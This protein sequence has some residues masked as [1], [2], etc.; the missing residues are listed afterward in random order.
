LA[1]IIN[2][3][4]INAL[5]YAY[6]DIE[7]PTLHI[8]INEEPNYLQLDIIDNGIGFDH[9]KITESHSFGL[10]L[11]NTLVQQLE[12]SIE[13]KQTIGTHWSIKIKIAKGLDRKHGKK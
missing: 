1:L 7:K 5:K 11:L 8:I 4:I 12:G 6:I 2:E 9:E 13:K 10:S 3:L